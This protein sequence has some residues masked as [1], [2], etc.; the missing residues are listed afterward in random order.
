MRYPYGAPRNRLL[1][2]LAVVLIHMASAPASGQET[3]TVDDARLT[4]APASD[5]LTYGRDYA[6][7]RYSPLDQI[8][9]GN[10][11]RLGL[12]WV[13]DIE[14]RGGGSPQV[15]P[16][17]VD[18]TM[19]FTASA[20]IV[21]AVDARDGTLR[22]KWDP[23]MPRGG[24][25]RGV[26]F[27]DGKVYT[28]LRDGRLV[29]LDAT[30]G[31][32]VWSRQTTPN[33]MSVYS[34][35][36]APRIVNGKVIIGNGGAENHGVR[37]YV[38]AYDA[39]TGEQVWRFY[40]VP[41]DPSEPFEHPE[42]EMAAETWAGEWW[43]YGG[44]GTAW[45]SFSFDPEANLLYIGTGNGQPWS[46]YW[47]SA[48]EGDNLFLNSILALNPDTGEMVWF[49]QAIPAENWDYTTTMN[50]I[51]ADIEIGGQE[52]KV[53]MT[54]NKAGFF[55][56]V[57]RITGEFISAEP[58]SEVNWASGYDSAGRPIETEIARF[59]TTGAWIAPGGT[60]W[61]GHNWHPMSFHPATG[62]AYVPGQNNATFY[63]LDPDFEPNVGGQS[64]GTVN[65]PDAPPAP[66][67][68]PVGYLAAWDPTTNSER[69]RI[70][71]DTP[72]NGGTLTT[73][74]N[75]LF[76][77]KR[78]GWIF[79][80]DATTGEILWR[81]RIGPDPAAPITFEIDGTQYVSVVTGAPGLPGRVWTFALDGEAASPL[82]E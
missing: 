59:D 61:G 69:W 53:V 54:A 77:L 68:D 70:P 79:A 10:V 18:G 22:W 28:G 80:H 72:R 57:D 20:G 47:R 75:L 76:S 17:V 66:V 56:V 35:S 45:D 16:L 78:D 44:G 29:A 40:T 62:L 60:Q 51:L 13:W 38:T 2:S 23:A 64:T 52:R 12:A 48:G 9:T 26:A 14:G 5:W 41:G 36:G 81:H 42:M 82:G 19:Y 43:K 11:S 24:S 21:Y 32:P 15:T 27:Y 6:E 74:D 30:T 65:R 33:D 71:L 73:A 67:F 46:H 7:T 25:S 55:Y 39:R 58:I 63:A 37:G 4:A 34:I 50:L 3:V 49:Y 1:A 31:Q 8:D